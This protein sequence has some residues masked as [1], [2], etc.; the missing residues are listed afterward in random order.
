M[1]KANFVGDISKLYTLGILLKK[2]NGRI[3]LDFIKR[4]QE[5]Q[6]IE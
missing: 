4:K 6:K 3:Q 1:K 5:L 2:E